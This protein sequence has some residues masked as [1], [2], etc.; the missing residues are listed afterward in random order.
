[1]DAVIAY[2][3]MLGTGV[4]FRTYHAEAPENRR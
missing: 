4:D 1:M 3:Q 2:L